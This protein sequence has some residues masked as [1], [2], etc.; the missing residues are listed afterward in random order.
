MLAELPDDQVV[1]TALRIRQSDWIRHG[2][3]WRQFC[4]ASPRQA[5]HAILAAEGDDRWRSEVIS[6]LLDVARET[7]D[8]ELQG[9][10]GDLLAV[11]PPDHVID[12]A[13]TAVWWVWERAKR[14]TQSDDEGILRAWDR[15]ARV[16]YAPRAS[17]A[18]QIVGLAVDAAIASPGGMLAIALGALMSKRS[19]AADEGFDEPFLSRLDSV[20]MSDSL[21]GLQGRMILV[22]D[23]AFLETIDPAWVSRQLIPRLHWTHAEAPP[24][25]RGR[26]G[27]DTG[28]PSLFTTLIDD[29]LEASRRAGPSENIDGL[30]CNLVQVSRWAIDRPASLPR[31]F[32]KCAQR[33]RPL[34]PNCGSAPLGCSGYGWPEREARRS[35]TPNAGA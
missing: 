7:D 12:V 34:P 21:A 16:V 11:L 3:V 22:R 19:W 15:L 2:D 14:S 25:W 28:R 6:P 1:A 30:A 33:S 18:L 29:F 17:E 32:Q 9:G 13:A 20:V 31:C 24:L 26:A 23:L 4:K 5:L 35:I 8:A 10:I 27:R